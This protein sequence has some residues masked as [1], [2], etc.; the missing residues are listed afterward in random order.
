MALRPSQARAVWARRPARVTSTR[1]VPWQP[2]STAAPVGSASTA[3]SPASRSGRSAEQALEAVVP[4]VDL[5]ALVED[6]GDVDRRARPRSRASSSST[7]TPALHVGTTPG[8]TARRPRC[9]PARC[10]WRAPCR[11]GR[12]APGA[13]AGRAR[14]G[15]P[16]CRPT[17][18]TSSHGTA[19]RR[20][21]RWSVMAP[22]VVAHR[23]DVDQL[24]GELEQVG[25]TSPRRARGGRR[26]S[27]ALSWRSPSAEAA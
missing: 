21:S 4:A 19:R 24:G 16:G 12:P 22:L 2:A 5:L 14:C 3:A 18:S 11:C 10:R 25:I 13:A 20:A 17:R 27:C 9:G 23:G 8:P 15:P 1:I 26:S 6:V 7:A